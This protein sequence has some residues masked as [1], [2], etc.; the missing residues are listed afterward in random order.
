[1]VKFVT[2]FGKELKKYWRK[3]NRAERRKFFKKNRKKLGQDWV[4][5][6]DEQITYKPIVGKRKSKTEEN[7][8]DLSRM[9]MGGGA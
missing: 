3:M 8:V 9:T 2:L 4:E 5:W 7:V 1:M 6:N